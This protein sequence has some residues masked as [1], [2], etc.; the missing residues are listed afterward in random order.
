MTHLWI[1][2]GGFDDIMKLIYTNVVFIGEMG[3][4][5]CVGII[6]FKGVERSSPFPIGIIRSSWIYCSPWFLKTQP[7]A[8]PE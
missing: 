4:L 7:H 3:G 6:L 5:M 2:T 8:E 1:K